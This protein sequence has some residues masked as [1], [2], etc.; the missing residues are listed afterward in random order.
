MASAS[1]PPTLPDL[2]HPAPPSDADEGTQGTQAGDSTA[3]LFDLF[4]GDDKETPVDEKE[5]PLLEQPVPSASEPGS[6]EPSQGEAETPLLLPVAETQAQTLPSATVDGS[7]PTE[8]S[9]EAPTKRRRLDEE[10]PK[11]SSR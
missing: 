9:S 6:V 2:E 10:S 8:L 4:S 7:I 1:A 11:M 3:D 5:T